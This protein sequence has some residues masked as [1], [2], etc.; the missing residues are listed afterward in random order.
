MEDF[1][2]MNNTFFRCGEDTWRYLWEQG[3][4]FA[5]EQYN[6]VV[7][8]ARMLRQRGLHVA[9]YGGDGVR[10]LKFAKAYTQQQGL[11]AVTVSYSLPKITQDP[12]GDWREQGFVHDASCRIVME[13]ILERKG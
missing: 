11:P 9:M 12:R 8:G 13:R 10:C 3:M 5:D 4:V 6:F 1:V 7:I 2:V